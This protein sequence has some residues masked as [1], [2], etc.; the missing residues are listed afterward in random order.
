MTTDQAIRLSDEE[1]LI[2][3]KK[4][5]NISEESAIQAWGMIRRED[6]NYK[7]INVKTFSGKFIEYPIDEIEDDDS[8]QI[9]GIPISTKNTTID[10]YH[11]QGERYISC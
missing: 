6:S 2:F 11:K 5:W 4:D 7:L 9:I 3:L 1:I 8:I 10:E